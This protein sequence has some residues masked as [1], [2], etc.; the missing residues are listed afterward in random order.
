MFHGDNLFQ[1][2]F[3]NDSE[4]VVSG[5][6]I[7]NGFVL[8][9]IGK[10]RT[11]LTKVFDLNNNN[12]CFFPLAHKGGRYYYVLYEDEKNTEQIKRSIFTF[13][14]N[15]KM[16]KILSTNQLIT[17]GLIIDESLYYTVYEPDKDHYVVYSIPLNEAVKQ[18]QLVKSDLETRDLYNIGNEL[19]FSSRERI[20]ND[21][22]T[23]EKKYENF[24]VGNLLIQ[25]YDDANNDMACSITDMN[26]NKVINIYKQPINFEV[27]GRFLYLYCED[28]LY[29]IPV[30]V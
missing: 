30:G 17:S 19:F 11:Q 6:S 15:Y 28:N 20:F 18:P 25:M 7:K 4:Y 5:H 14:E 26:S 12:D 1:Y 23:F 16:Q 13:D 27:K 8:L 21:K 10:G 22:K 3:E 29:E 2:V 9:K 24:V